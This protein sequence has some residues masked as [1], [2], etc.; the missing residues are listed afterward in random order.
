M[1]KYW[2]WGRSESVSVFV[3]LDHIREILGAWWLTLKLT[4]V[5]DLHHKESPKYPFSLIYIT[6]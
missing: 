4:W 6:Q 1:K 3:F 2:W 5:G